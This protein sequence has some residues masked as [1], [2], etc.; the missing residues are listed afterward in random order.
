MG[1][2]DGMTNDERADTY[3]G[4]RR[5]SQKA[6]LGKDLDELLPREDRTVPDTVRREDS[7]SRSIR[8]RGR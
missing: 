2:K 3:Q 4:L 7:R 6:A 8:R 1:N 5:G